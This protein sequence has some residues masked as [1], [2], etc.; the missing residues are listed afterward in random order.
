M[1]KLVYIPSGLPTPEF[2]ILLSKCQEI[3]DTKKHNL[4][5]VTYSKDAKAPCPFNLYSQKSIYSASQS[6]LDKGL[7]QLKGNFKLISVP[8]INWRKN[9]LTEFEK[10]NIT[11]K[12]KIKDLNYKKI[13]IGLSSWAT[14]LDGTRDLNLDGYFSKSLM[15]RIFKS[16]KSL[17]NNFEKILKNEKIN[18][19]FMYNGRRHNTRPL[20][21]LANK[22]RIKLQNLEHVTFLNNTK[23]VRQFKNFMPN[24]LIFLKK[25]IMRHWNKNRGNDEDVKKYFLYRK[26]NLLKNNQASHVFNQSKT[27]LPDN[28]NEN[29]INIV[30]FISSQ[31]EYAAN[32]GEWFN[33][34]YKD[35]NYSLVKISKD[36]LKKNVEN[37][38]HLWIRI[39]PYLKGVKWKF[40]TDMFKFSEFK[41]IDVIKPESPI[42]TYRLMEKCDK[43]LGYHSITT[44]EANFWRKPSML[45]GRQ[46]FENMNCCH[47][48]N[49]HQDVIDFIFSNK[50]K[51]KPKI[52]SLKIASFWIHGGINQKYFG[53]NMLKG[54]KF[55]NKQFKL[56]FFYRFQFYYGKLLE[57]FFYNKINYYLRNFKF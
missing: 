22:K 15:L 35:Q 3:L 14:Y 26:N 55:N 27:L 1:K 31:D 9:K 12:K 56:N 32:G 36:F 43:V 13:D 51:L 33:S 20:L 41:N 57:K 46:Y 5:I 49:N 8:D 25:E 39:H 45:L 11:N 54:Y 30:Y 2:E 34:V 28:W 21:R 7:A 48:A 50:H 24:D 29:K 4:V 44:V 38:Y 16:S 42:S 10:K 53:G 19:I 40:N 18:E 52:N 37:K 23:G 47:R 6:K 17:V